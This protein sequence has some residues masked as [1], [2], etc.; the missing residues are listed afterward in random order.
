M[1][2]CKGVDNSS[3]HARYQEVLQLPSRPLL[4]PKIEITTINDGKEM[5]TPGFRIGVFPRQ[6]T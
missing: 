5:D 2:F 4:I 6:K 1:V 3:A